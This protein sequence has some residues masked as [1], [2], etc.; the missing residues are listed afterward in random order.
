MRHQLRKR[1]QWRQLLFRNKLRFKF[2]HW[3]E[4]PD[5]RE[6]F[7]DSRSVMRKFYQYTIG[8]FLLFSMT[9]VTYSLHLANARSGGLLVRLPYW[10]KHRR[11]IPVCPTVLLLRAGLF[12]IYAVPNKI[13]VLE[14]IRKF[15]F[16]YQVQLPI[17]SSLPCIY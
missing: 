14:E 4:L 3:R 9:S 15:F 17:F 16:L 10:A 13:Y 7:H 12:R 5:I 2:L 1:L 8:N 11:A 6:C